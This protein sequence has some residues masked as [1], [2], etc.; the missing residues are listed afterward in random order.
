M[1]MPSPLAIT[2]DTNIPAIPAIRAFWATLCEDAGQR[3]TLVPTAASELLRRV[4]LE[5]EREWAK[6]LKAVNAEQ[7]IGWTKID[8]RRLS[9]TAS[10]AARDWLQEEMGRQGAIYAIT[11]PPSPIIEETEAELE[12]VLPEDIFDLLT[13]NGIRDRKIVVE[14]LARGFNILASNNI[15]SIDHELLKEWIAN[16]VGRRMNIKTTILRP[17]DAEARL[18][19]SCGKSVTWTLNAL[20]RASVNDPY[21]PSA[22]AEEM[23]LAMKDFPERGMVELRGRI[24]RMMLNEA[25]LDAALQNMKAHGASLAQ[26]AN[27]RMAQASAKAVSRKAEISLSP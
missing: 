13:D 19:E 11:A 18:R 23:A 8:I 20:A 26:R 9:T 5:T 3:M 24:E 7:R 22:A 6:R 15:E 12:D 25:T 2:F 21:S 14:A 1:P 17:P 10:T 16:P 27:A 4:R